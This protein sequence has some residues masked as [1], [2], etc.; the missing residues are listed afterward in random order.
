M[1][2]TFDPTAHAEVL[3]IRRASARLKTFD[4]AGCD[5]YTI[6]T[7]CCMCLSSML[8]AHIDRAYYILEEKESEAIG[9][10]DRDFY[11]E[12]GRPLDQRKI[13]PMGHLPAL[14]DKAWAV[15]KAW[16][17]KPDKVTY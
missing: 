7:P 14:R 6:G 5:L 1:L 17:E 12:V 15:Y 16:D 11:D 4:L 2:A 13:I 8:W 9:L 3:A 10:G